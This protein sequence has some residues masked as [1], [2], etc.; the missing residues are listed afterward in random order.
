M[1]TVNWCCSAEAYIRLPVRLSYV[2]HLFLP[3]NYNLRI[4]L[5]FLD[6]PE[7]WQSNECYN[8]LHAKLSDL[9]T[10]HDQ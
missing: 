7:F 1:I 10:A 2:G 3:G 4:A 5:V 9:S 8:T 6:L